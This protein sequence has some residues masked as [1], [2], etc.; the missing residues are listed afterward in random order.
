MTIRR[1]AVAALLTF[2][3]VAAS[4]VPWSN[5]E[6]FCFVLN[7][8]APS[9]GVS[10]PAG[11]Q[12]MRV[13][14]QTGGAYVVEAETRSYAQIESRYDYVL[15]NRIRSRIDANTLLPSQASEQIQEGR[16]YRVEDTRYNQSS[17]TGS[18]NRYRSAHSLSPGE[19][20][21]NR[22]IRW[23]GSE[24]VLDVLSM[25]YY[26][27]GQDLPA[28]ADSGQEIRFR[29]MDERSFELELVRARVT[30]DTLRVGN[31]NVNVF[32]VRQVSNNGAISNIEMS[33]TRDASRLPL[34]INLGAF[35]VA[36]VGVLEIRGSMRD[37]GAVR[38]NHNRRR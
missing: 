22:S 38:A 12:I 21:V 28:L 23:S 11:T 3:P 27:R 33:I 4:A 5:N 9:L 36:V 24:P 7:V 6:E 2:T 15:Y 13:V 19:L 10:A 34:Q 30:R 14:S 17:R 29:Y 16:Y 35:Q 32:K 18:F 37:C 25:V 26:V 8:S 20:D 1:L 31:R